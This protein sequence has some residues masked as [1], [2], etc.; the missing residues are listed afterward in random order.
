MELG[1]LNKQSLDN[2]MSVHLDINLNCIITE[3]EEKQSQM[4]TY[5]YL[6]INHVLIVQLTLGSC[7]VGEE[8]TLRLCLTCACCRGHVESPGFASASN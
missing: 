4:T 8:L 5:H 1:K 2:H 3:T 6:S 7:D